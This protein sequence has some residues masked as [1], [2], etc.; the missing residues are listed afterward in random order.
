MTTVPDQKY[1]LRVTATG[2]VRDSDGN[3]IG[4]EPIEAIAI[5]TEDE[6][7]KLFEGEPS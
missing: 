2:T 4:Q 3:I 5:L 6:I 1:E 7:H